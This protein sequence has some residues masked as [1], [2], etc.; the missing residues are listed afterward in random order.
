MGYSLELLTND[1][2]AACIR[3]TVQNLEAQ[4][5]EGWPCWA[6]SNHDVERVLSR[7]GNGDASGAPG[8]YVERMVCSLRGSVRVSGR[9]AR[10]DRGRR[11]F[12]NPCR[13]P[14]ASPSGPPS[15][16]ATA[17]VRQSPGT[18]A[19]MPFS[20]WASRGCPYRPSIRTGRGTAG[21]RATLRAQWLSRVHGSAQVAAAS[22]WGDIRFIDTPVP[23]PRSPDVTATT[24]CWLHSIC[25]MRPLRHRC[26][27]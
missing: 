4:M 13:I 18:R 23:V 24:P 19:S 20:A 25:R 6:I 12:P 15:R 2:N 26:Q 8:R 11:T 22:R 21:R 17:A 27:A 7:W 3:S 16:A 1:F 14:T 5:L 9:G 10:P